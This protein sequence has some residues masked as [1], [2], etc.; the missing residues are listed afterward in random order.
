MNFFL[1]IISKIHNNFKLN[2]IH[3][4]FTI[5]I[6]YN[7]SSAKNVRFQFYLNIRWQN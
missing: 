4:I 6:G 1:T 7:P 2:K 3:E 5:H